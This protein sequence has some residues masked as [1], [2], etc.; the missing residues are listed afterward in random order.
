MNK[1][2]KTTSAILLS[3][4][5]LGM[6][7]AAQAQSN[8]GDWGPDGYGKVLA[9]GDFNGD[10]YSDQAIANPSLGVCSSSSSW[11]TKAGSVEV[12]YGTQ[13]GLTSYAQVWDHST[14]GMPHSI[15]CHQNYLWLGTALA[16]GDFNAGRPQSGGRGPLRSRRQ[17]STPEKSGSVQSS[18]TRSNCSW[19]QRSRAS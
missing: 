3:A 12:K 11:S 7:S 16:A 15:I 5:S 10:G 17:S 1:L 2:N 9:T 4:M 8:P 14:P 19:R 6:G 13:W 18:T